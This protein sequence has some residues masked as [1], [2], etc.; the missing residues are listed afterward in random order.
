MYF[1]SALHSPCEDLRDLWRG[2]R[3][4]DYM[5]QGFGD[6]NHPSHIE[7]Y[8]REC[9]PMWLCALHAQGWPLYRDPREDWS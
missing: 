7:V 8:S 6:K 4:A 5:R 9:R 3:V 1:L 2:P